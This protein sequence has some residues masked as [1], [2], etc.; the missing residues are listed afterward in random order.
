MPTVVQ[1]HFVGILQDRQDLGSA[2]DQML[3]T[4]YFSMSEGA[5]TWP[6]LEA[7]IK[8]TPGA[9]YA[10]A[11]LE[12]EFPAYDG[13]MNYAA[14]RECVEDYYRSAVGQAGQMF[15]IGPGATNIRM[16]NNRFGFEQDCSFEA[17]TD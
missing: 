7:H 12:V 9:P 5:R 17:S 11:P 13:P 4:V 8:Q 16:R 14:F 3:S 1:V 15:R 2:D 6:Q 10:D